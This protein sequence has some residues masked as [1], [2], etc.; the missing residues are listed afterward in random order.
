LDLGEDDVDFVFL[1]VVEEVVGVGEVEVLGA[2]NGGLL[3]GHDQI[4][5]LDELLVGV[6]LVGQVRVEEEPHA[7][8]E[9]ETSLTSKRQKVQQLP[10]LFIIELIVDVEAAE[11]GEEEL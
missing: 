7:V 11:L 5:G 10:L 1:D 3:D 4:L 9:K 2:L 6:V 8:G